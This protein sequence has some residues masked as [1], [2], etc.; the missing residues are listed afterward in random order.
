MLYNKKVIEHFQSPH[1]MGKMKNPDG[2]GEVGNPI[3]GDLMT[4]YIKVGQNSKKQEIIKDIK[5]ET[6]GCVAAIA[7][8]S[9][10]TE[11]AKGKNFDEA[12]KIK[13]SDVEKALGSL[14]PVK[15]H[16]ADLAVKALRAAIE[17]Y[18]GLGPKI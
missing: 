5:F 10:I 15:V 8:S 3:C 13:F 14:P 18:N 16:C 11:M 9:M 2:V 17:D 7:T 6:L 12:L 4:I 1:N